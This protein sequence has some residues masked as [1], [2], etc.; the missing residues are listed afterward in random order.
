MKRI[1]HGMA[2]W[3]DP[4][5]LAKIAVRVVIS[6]VFGAFADR[7]ELVAAVNPVADN[8]FDPAQDY[9]D[10][11]DSGSG[12]WID[13]IA[14]TG[15]GWASTRAVAQLATA[16]QLRPEGLDD[17]LPRASVLVMGGDQVYP[18]A[19]YQAYAERLIA[20]WDSA[21][22]EVPRRPGREADP[23]DLGDLYAIPGN[24]DWYD[25]LI[26]FGHIFA[27][28]THGAAHIASTA[29]TGKVVARR[30]TRQVRS[31]FALKLPHGWW[32]WGTDSQLEGFIDQPQVDY[33]RYVA[34]QWMEPGSKVILCVGQPA[35]SYVNPDDPGPAFNSF[36]FLSRLVSDARGKDGSLM[37]HQLKLV[38]T[39]DSHHYSRYV[40]DDV[41]YVTAGGGGAF[42]HPTHNLRDHIAFEWD[43]P[44]AARPWQAG[45]KEYPRHFALARDGGA[46]DAGQPAGGDKPALFPSR[47][48]SWLQ[49]FKTLAF[50]AYNPMFVLLYAAFYGLLIWAMEARVADAKAGALLARLRFSD[51]SFAKAWLKVAE[52]VVFTPTV[53]V[54][55]LLTIGVYVYF[56][57][58]AGHQRRRI[59]AG[60]IHA[61]GHIAI[62]LAVTAAV[63]PAYDRWIEIKPSSAIKL[64]AG[65]GL[66]SRAAVGSEGVTL[67][68]PGASER[69]ARKATVQAANSPT[70]DPG[71]GGGHALASGLIVAFLA[72]L[73]SACWFGAYLW[74]SLTLSGR[75]WNEAFSAFR[76]RHFKNMLRMKIGPDGLTL[77]PIG[78]R[79]V[80]GTDV[81]A[82][83]LRPE[84]IE[85]PVTIT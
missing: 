83:D 28:R 24:H 78:L 60:L 56:A 31:Y 1:K 64:S 52:T 62:F 85:T 30:Q 10:V 45:Q 6:S 70:A 47:R 82:R 58:W 79:H 37:H 61:L 15:D 46:A 3:Y 49:S 7:R 44:S 35:W 23:S 48:D 43:S 12:F 34:Q 81:V 27:R 53:V 51:D 4:I 68:R 75:H 39:G 18:T 2:H 57:D 25:G 9:A 80:P 20:P 71:T 69:A 22:E 29:R 33:F 66:G 76:S 40:E 17:A 50:A 55:L 74:L 8:P 16:E 73:A 77:Y 72:A 36:A 54:L 63:L 59:T 41:H 13:F 32:L 42:L 26:A 19:S 65:T 38:L 14:D 84:M 67:P 5:P 11:D 21:C